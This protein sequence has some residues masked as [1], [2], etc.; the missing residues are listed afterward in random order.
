MRGCIDR[1]SHGGNEEE[2]SQDA[3]PPHPTTSLLAGPFL[4]P[5]VQPRFSAHNSGS[6]SAVA[7]QA[8]ERGLWPAALRRYRHRVPAQRYLFPAL[9]KIA[10]KPRRER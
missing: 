8:M 1:I 6:D 9:Q 3:P 7:R 10:P 4:T 5:S 2:R